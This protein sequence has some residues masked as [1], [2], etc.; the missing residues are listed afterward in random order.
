MYRIYYNL[1]DGSLSA[2]KAIEAD[3]LLQ[4]ESMLTRMDSESDIYVYDVKS[5]KRVL[6]YR[7]DSPSEYFFEVHSGGAIVFKKV[8]K[9]SLIEGLDKI[10][11]ILS[12][13]YKHGFSDW[14][15]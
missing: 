6:I 9:Q 10:S 14:E 3:D 15:D 7:P 5:K 2:D 12:N 8:D 4:I 1:I 13:P 11:S